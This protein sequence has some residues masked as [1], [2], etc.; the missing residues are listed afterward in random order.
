MKRKIYKDDNGKYIKHNN[1]KF[2]PS[3]LTN[4]LTK[5]SKLTNN[6]DSHSTDLAEGSSVNFEKLS[7]N[8]VKVLSENFVEYW[9]SD[10]IKDSSKQDSR[11]EFLKIDFLKSLT[12]G[13]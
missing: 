3:I 7:N 6:Q 4:K 11:E 13:D 5:L 2:R 10:I 1:I 12:K 9:E 8:S